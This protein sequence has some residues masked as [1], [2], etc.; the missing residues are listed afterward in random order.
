MCEYSVYTT[1]LCLIDS[2][3]VVYTKR[4]PLKYL[5]INLLAL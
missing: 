3:K 4:N 5:T 2:N 1:N